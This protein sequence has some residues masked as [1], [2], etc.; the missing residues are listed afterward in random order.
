MT[1]LKSHGVTTVHAKRLITK[2]LR[3]VKFIRCDNAGDEHMSE[4]RKICHAQYCIVLEYTAPHTPQYNGVVE[5]MFARDAR[6]ALAM[7]IAAGWTKELQAKLRAEAIK[8]AALL[9]DKLPNTRSAV[10]PDEQFYGKKSELYSNLIEF[11]RGERRLFL[12]FVVFYCTGYHCLRETVAWPVIIGVL[13][14]NLRDNRC[15]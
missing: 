5:R 2:G 6:C 10:P 1:K 8:T 14:K 11:G 13:E 9:D 4:L 3:E 7:I 15:Y 12:S